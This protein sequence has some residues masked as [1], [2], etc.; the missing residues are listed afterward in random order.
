MS[1]GAAMAGAGGAILYAGLLVL[2]GAIVL[3]LI[4][5]GLDAWLAA[6]IVAVVVLIIGAVVTS[7]G[8]KQIQSTNVAPTQ[9]AESVREDVEFVKEQMK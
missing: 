3:G 4:A 7:T 8:V 9:T 6:L 2:L 5:A 1:R